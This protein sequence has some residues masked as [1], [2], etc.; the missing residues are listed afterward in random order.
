MAMD[1]DKAVY[2]DA[3]H[4]DCQVGV[5]HC[6]RIPGKS[7]IVSGEYRSIASSLVTCEGAA[8]LTSGTHGQM[9]GAV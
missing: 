3:D 4:R 8:R 5:H 7:E 9:R 1:E 2:F 6:G